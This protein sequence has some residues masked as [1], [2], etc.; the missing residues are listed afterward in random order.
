MADA[1]LAYEAL[2]KQSQLKVDQLIFKLSNKRANP[3]GGK[4]RSHEENVA[5]VKSFMGKT[6]AWEGV[7]ALEYQRQ[8]RG[9]YRE[10]V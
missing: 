6:R 7:D 2:D 5:L 8:L 9:E 10:N 3:S 1:V 4:K